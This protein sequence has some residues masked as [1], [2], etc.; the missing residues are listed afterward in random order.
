MRDHLVASQAKQGHER[1]SW[2]FKDKW[3]DI[4]GRLY[5]TA[6]CTMMLEVYYRYLPMYEKIEEF[7]L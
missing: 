1:G 7:P 3:G 6:M 5:T 2:H 4:G